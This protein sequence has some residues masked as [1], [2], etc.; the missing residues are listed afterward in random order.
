[1]TRQETEVLHAIGRQ[2]REARLKR[3][4]TQVEVADKA[5]LN[6]G[7]YSRVERG[8]ANLS[9]VTLESILKVLKVKSSKILPF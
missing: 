5:N 9:V 7:Y 4:L 3:G 6:D 1:M 2:L 8:E